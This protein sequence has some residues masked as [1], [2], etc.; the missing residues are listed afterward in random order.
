MLVKTYLITLS[1]LRGSEVEFNILKDNPIEEL[2]VWRCNTIMI[3][4]KSE[5]TSETP[6]KGTFVNDSRTEKCSPQT[7][8]ESSSTIPVLV[9]S[10]LVQKR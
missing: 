5:Q 6:E 7:N 10:S 8:P 2:E 9:I 1:G 3:T 4:R